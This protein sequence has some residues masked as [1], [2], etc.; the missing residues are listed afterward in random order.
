M[1]RRPLFVSAAIDAKPTRAARQGGAR[2]WAQR[3]LVGDAG[4]LVLAVVYLLA[5][6]PVAPDLGNAE[7]LLLILSN[8][9]PLVAVVL[10]QSFVL[11]TGGI[12]LSVTSTIALTSVAGAMA[13]VSPRLG[14]AGVPALL[15]G[16]LVMLTVGAA[17]GLCNG[18]AITR[19]AMPPFMVTLAMMMFISGGA[20]WLS[21]SNGI[22][23]LPDELAV[24]AQEG[25]GGVPFCLLAIAPMAF[26]AHVILTRTLLGRWLF[27]VGGNMKAARVSGVPVSGAV[28][29]AY[30]LSGVSAAVASLLYTGRLET[31]SPVLG[32]RVFL[33]VIG[34]A[35]IGGVSLFGGKGS[36]VGAI[37][38]VLFITVIDNSFNIMGF[39]SFTV[40]IA[41][42]TV[43][44]LAALFDGIR[45]RRLSRT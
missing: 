11:I 27:A 31:G 37:S 33:D 30:V 16:T 4:V 21:S 43:I 29:A 9:L 10:G 28:V 12:D 34:A 13:M 23:G 41:K 14:L 42:G 1:S 17:V 45:T 2:A 35:V 7:N 38:G 19:L 39:S 25:W 6:L 32:Q 20:V 5:L 8:M 40:L 44:L 15:V 36:V 26:A 18:L 24:F 22:P 3:L